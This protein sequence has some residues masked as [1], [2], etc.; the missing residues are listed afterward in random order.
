MNIQN[1][2]ELVGKQVFDT[3]GTAIGTIDKTWQSWR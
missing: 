2:K 1:P 3:N